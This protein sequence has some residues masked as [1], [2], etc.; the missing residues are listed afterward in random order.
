MKTVLGLVILSLTLTGCAAAQ[1][2]PEP[3]ASQSQDS[4]VTPSDDGATEPSAGEAGTPS[5]TPSSATAK[6]STPGT[7][8]GTTATPTPTATS[9]PVSSNSPAAG[10]TMAEVSVNN[11]TASC[12]V[13]ID[14]RVYNLTAWISLHP[15]GA[16]AISGLCGT[17]GTASFT[18]QHAGDSTP[19]RELSK[20][21]IGPLR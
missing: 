15:G 21:E 1:T 2:S 3:R 14:S 8:T 20:Y 17:D 11:T 19:A 5:P 4:S 18:S 16:G 12:W 6:P 10:F 7:S 13:V 9:T